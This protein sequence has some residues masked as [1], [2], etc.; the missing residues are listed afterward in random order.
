MSLRPILAAL[1]AFAAL[2]AMAQTAPSQDVAAILTRAAPEA[3]AAFAVD[4]GVLVHK[5]SGFSCPAGAGGGATLSG[6]A[7]G[8]LPGQAGADPAYC[9]YSDATGVV[10][11]L[12]FA[13][14][15]PAAP[16]LDEAFCRGLPKAL[17]LTLGAGGLPGNSSFTAPVQ[18]PTGPE[19]VRGQAVPVWQCGLMRPPYTRPTIVL[20]V[21]ALRPAGGWTVLALHTP[22]PPPCC[23]GYRDAVLPSFYMR[24]L[25]LAG[26]AVRAA[27][28]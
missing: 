3:Q 16:V 8:A 23:R 19:T 6:V 2:P 27:R 25:L 17:K 13:K 21:A 4:K 9:E 22:A 11:R 7:L 18:A 1:L 24:P 26:E 15:D 10:E 12:A 14:D 20:N 28:L 5:A